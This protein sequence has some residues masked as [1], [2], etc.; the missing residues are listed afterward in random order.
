MYGTQEVIRAVVKPGMLVKHEGKTYKAS[1]NTKGK[2]YLYSLT[3]Q[4]R[5]TDCFVEILLNSRGEP[6]IN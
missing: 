4:K 2:L 5:I 3:E 6:L 1:A